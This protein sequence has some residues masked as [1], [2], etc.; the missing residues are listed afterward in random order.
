MALS[1]WEVV[2]RLVVAS[3]A[4]VVIGFERETNGR[5]AGMRTH[6]VVALGSALFTMG[7]AYGFAD[8]VSNRD[9]AR[10][11]AQ[12]AAGVGFIGAG[13]IL[14]HGGAVLGITTA[15]SI[16]LSAAAGVAVGAGAYVAVVT[17]IVLSLLLLGA[18][19]AMRT[20]VTRLGRTT[21]VV[22]LEY[23]RGYG[24]LGPLLRELEALN[25]RVESLSI[26][27]DDDSGIAGGSRHVVIRVVGPTSSA[28]ST[29]LR[30]LADRDE[31]H[32]FNVTR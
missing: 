31:V 9:P 14:R 22:D 10:V 23:E 24:T 28:L 6:A 30:E 25:G 1:T 17:A 32:A 15:A 18:L 2:L 26:E 20:L 21:T 4:G 12:V 27:D 16:W 11:A 13:A 3:V 8:I 19:R 29:S 7:G 5:T